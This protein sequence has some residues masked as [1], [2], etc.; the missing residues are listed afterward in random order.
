PEPGAK[1]RIQNVYE[2]PSAIRRVL[3]EA[4]ATPTGVSALGLPSVGA[5]ATSGKSAAYAD[6]FAT[7]TA[8]YGLPQGL[9]SAVAKA[10]SGYNPNA[11][12][13]AGARGLMQLMPAT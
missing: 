3:P 11:V 4:G 5:P 1:V 10:E 13:G 8:K 6:L 2:T 12:S 9:L 7:A